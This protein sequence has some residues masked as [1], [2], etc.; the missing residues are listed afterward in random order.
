MKNAT[1]TAILNAPINVKKKNAEG[2]YDTIETTALQDNFAHCP[3]PKDCADE[4]A[5]SAL[6]ALDKV[7]DYME[8]ASTARTDN[9]RDKAVNKAYDFAKEYLRLVG[10]SAGVGNVAMLTAVFAPKKQTV[11]GTIKGGYTTKSTFVK[12]A[13]YLT[14]HVLE[15]GNWCDVKAVNKAKKDENAELWAQIEKN[16]AEYEAQQAKMAAML[17][18]F[19]KNH[20]VIEGI[21]A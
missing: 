6:N 18:Y 11:K 7:F 13:L 3:K 20:I 17:E 10:L 21:N 1:F 5:K 9:Q 12:Y 15:G 2:K 14:N 19:A 4:S 16:K 8:T